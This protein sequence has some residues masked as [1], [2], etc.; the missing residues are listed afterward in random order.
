MSCLKHLEVEIHD[1]NSQAPFLVRGVHD[2]YW[3]DTVQEV[4]EVLVDELDIKTR[5][6]APVKPIE[7]NDMWFLRWIHDRLQNV[8]QENPGLDYMRKLRQIGG[9][10]DE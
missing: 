10:P 5:V 9:W 1:G 6:A 7:E 4:L 8:H 2:I 3:L